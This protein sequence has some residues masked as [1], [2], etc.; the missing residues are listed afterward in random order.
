MVGAKAAWPGARPLLSDGRPCRWQ[1]M[2]YSPLQGASHPKAEAE[3]VQRVHLLDLLLLPRV[4]LGHDPGLADRLQTL[5]HLEKVHK[6]RVL[7]CV[8]IML[9]A[10]GA[11]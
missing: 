2:F 6:F 1:L 4:H 5:H 11:P 9:A 10:M 7:D 3:A 8:S